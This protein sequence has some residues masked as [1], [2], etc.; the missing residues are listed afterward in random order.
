MEDSLRE[1]FRNWFFDDVNFISMV[2]TTLLWNWFKF[3]RIKQEKLKK[4]T[5]QESKKGVYSNRIEGCTIE[6]G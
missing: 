5:P 2:E 4:E 6:Y 1:I 3:S